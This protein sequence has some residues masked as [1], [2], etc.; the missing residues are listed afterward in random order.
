LRCTTLQNSYAPPLEQLRQHTLRSS[1]L[2]LVNLWAA[3]VDVRYCA[4]QARVEHDVAHDAR[5]GQPQQK[6]AG[7]WGT[8]RR[9]A[10]HNPS[11]IAQHAFSDAVLLGGH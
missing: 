11:P 10:G 1:T 8:G 5:L 6:Q 7:E 3:G 4:G 9:R 2:R